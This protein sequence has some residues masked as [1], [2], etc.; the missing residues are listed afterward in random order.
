MYRITALRV[1]DIKRIREIA[2]E[3]QAD[4]GLLL[5]AGKNGNGKSSI[6]DS[7][8]MVLGGAGAL[9]ADP[10]RHGARDGEIRIELRSPDRTIAATRK[11]RPDRSTELEVRD[12]GRD[13]AVVRKP[14]AVLDDIRGARFLDPLA[15]LDAEAPKQRAQLLGLLPCAAELAELDGQRADAY[16]RREG[17]GRDLRRAEGDLERCAP[18]GPIPEQIDTAAALEAIA[19]AQKVRQAVAAAQS[20]VGDARRRWQSAK[21][22]VDRLAAELAEA[23][24]RMADADAAGRAA[25]EALNAQE[26]DADAAETIR[27]NQELVAQAQQRADERATAIA[28]RDRRARA[29]EAVKRLAD[30]RD[31]LTTTIAKIDEAK[32]AILAAAAFPVP[33]LGFTEDGVTYRGVPLDQASGAER[34]RVAIGVAIAASKGLADVWI[35][36]AALLDDDSL[37]AL[38][39][40]AREHDVRIWLEL[41]KAPDAEDV[42]VISDGMVAS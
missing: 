27:R 29:A 25:V 37:A 19:A 34:L 16:Q 42:I 31:A 21:A 30:E 18:A 22:D 39:Q 4:S 11:V 26:S 10:V 6:L 32:A 15:F 36:D 2:I 24:Q 23:Q 7:I 14:Q 3:P 1:R 5:I 41:I 33:G 35:R 12:V 28:A 13:G 9:P 8:E 20:K 40:L 38:E 17:S